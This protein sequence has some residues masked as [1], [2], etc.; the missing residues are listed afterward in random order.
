MAGLG[1][2]A[3]TVSAGIKKRT[4]TQFAYFGHS[5]GDNVANAAGYHY[6]LTFMNSYQAFAAFFDNPQQANGTDPATS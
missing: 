5:K 2:F 1:G 6:P 4:I 3:R